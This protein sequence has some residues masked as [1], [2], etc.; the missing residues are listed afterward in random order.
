MENGTWIEEWRW[1]IKSNSLI[2][3]TSDSSLR[4]RLIILF[5]RRPILY[6]FCNA[7]MVP[8]TVVQSI[9]NITVYIWLKFKRHLY[10][11]S[12]KPI[13]GQSIL[14][15]SAFQ[16]LWYSQYISMKK[17]S[18]LVWKS[19][20]MTQFSIVSKTIGVHGYSLWN[21]KKLIWL[22]YMNLISKLSHQVITMCSNYD[23]RN[24]VM[25]KLKLIEHVH[26]NR[27]KSIVTKIERETS[28]I[29]LQ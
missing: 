15:H 5:G 28:H 11:N 3:T 20:K 18:Q 16:S 29:N 17:L 27:K 25:S 14:T 9:N 2:F 26:R 13:N 8:F 4:I 22:V 21:K 12:N 24:R 7:G 1:K 19:L 23:E 10:C 6:N